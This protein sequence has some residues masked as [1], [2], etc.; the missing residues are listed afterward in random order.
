MR[1]RPFG[2]TGMTVS[3]IALGTWAFASQVYGRVTEEE[4]RRTVDAA[5]EAGINVFDTAPLYGTSERDGV[6]EEVLGRALGKRRESVLVMTKF[7]RRSSASGTQFN[8]H[9]ARRS[10]E[11]SLRRLGT[12]HIDVLFFH[13]PFGAHEIEDD[14]WDELDR[15]RQEGKIRIVGHSISL[16]QETK[17]LAMD[18]A[19]ERNIGAIQVVLSLLNR[20]SEELI[21]QMEQLGVGVVARESMANG[22]LSGTIT[23]DTVFGSDNLNNRYSRAE[24]IERVDQV[25]RLGF[26][27]RGAI[28]SMPQAAMRW[29][30]DHPGVSTVLTGASN[31]AQVSDCAAASDA[32]P[33]SEDEL[34]RARS[35]HTKDYPAA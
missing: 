2:S 11:E 14:V 33:Y 13:S 34:A 28:K 32:P 29:V 23:R 16:F 26:L 31:A 7:G 10:V 5:L 21:S 35:V 17:D 25:D 27:V 12:E 6:A 19:R 3:E 22:F 30:L 1:T 8:A 15:L 18:W 20:E 9:G 24:I 4:A